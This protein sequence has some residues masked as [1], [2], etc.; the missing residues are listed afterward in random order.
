MSYGAYG[1][2]YGIKGSMNIY[3]GKGV[4]KWKGGDKYE[5]TFRYAGQGEETY[6][7]EGTVQF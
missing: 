4:R 3:L 1:N 5:G 7:A 2:L 6:F